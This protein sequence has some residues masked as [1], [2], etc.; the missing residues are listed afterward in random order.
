[1]QIIA[2]CCHSGTI[3]GISTSVTKDMNS[4]NVLGTDL[5]YGHSDHMLRKKNFHVE[6]ALW[7]MS[8]IRDVLI[9][10][11]AD[12]KKSDNRGTERELKPTAVDLCEKQAIKSTFSIPNVVRAPFF[13]RIDR[14]LTKSC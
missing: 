3:A 12:R 4:T 8:I 2:D 1:M 14:V 10:D 13:H 11:S 7:T 6:G 9:L 5:P